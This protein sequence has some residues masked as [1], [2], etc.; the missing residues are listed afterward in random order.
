MFAPA[1]LFF[2]AAVVILIERRV[3]AVH[4]VGAV[5]ALAVAAHRHPQRADDGQFRDPCPVALD[6]ALVGRAVDRVGLIIRG[7]HSAANHRCLGERR[8]VVVAVGQPEVVPA[9]L[10]VHVRVARHAAPHPE[11]AP[12][13]RAAAHALDPRIGARL[14][15][16]LLRYFRL[17][18]RFGRALHPHDCRTLEWTAP[19]IVV[20]G[21]DLDVV[22]ACP[23][24]RLSCTRSHQPAGMRFRRCRCWPRSM[25]ETGPPGPT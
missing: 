15:G 1:V 22:I 9:A 13:G 17:P 20:S 23:R 11:C 3:G 12:V 5:L 18:G 24:V 6:V 25:S 21:A 10:G 14:G 8:P 16:L 2:V 19:V 4:A 7:A